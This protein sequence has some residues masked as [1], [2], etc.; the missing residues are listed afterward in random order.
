MRRSIR[1][2]AATAGIAALLLSACS[3][4]PTSEADTVLTMFASSDFKS[5]VDPLVADFEAANPGVKVNVTYAGGNDFETTEGT[6]IASGNGP[7]IIDALPGTSGA[8]A[9]QQLIKDG[10]VLN[11]SDQPW[12]KDV[13][14]SVNGQNQPDLTDDKNVYFYPVLVQPMGA[15]YNDATLKEA[16]L[17]A[18]TTWSGVLKFCADARK[19]GKVPYSLGISDQW[20]TQ[21][22][23]YTLVNSLLYGADPAWGRNGDLTS[24]KVKFTD[25]AWVKTFEQYDEMRKNDC[26]TDNPNAVNLDASLAPVGSGKAAGIVQVG[27]LFSN[28]QALNKDAS[29][30]LL[31]LPA[32]DNEADTFMPAAPAHE[33]AVYSKSKNPEL[34]LKFINFLAEPANA[35]K[36]VETVGGAV[37]AVPNDSFKPPALLEN[38][39]MYVKNDKIRSFPYLPNSEVA[40]ALMVGTQNMFL[41]K[42]TPK[43]VVQSMQDAVKP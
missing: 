34:A 21:L 6:A 33:F 2:A 30:T 32:T 9:T 25:S 18:P 39:Y 12:A 10:T 14:S 22:V 16:G 23:P 7:D 11:L 41:G 15:F 3:N 1:L 20:I 26:F 31:P 38:F 24:G 42:T 13:P 37:V 19:A 35:N 8:I 43:E 5:A 36:F 29:Y 17:T 28:L 27:G 4:N 40:N